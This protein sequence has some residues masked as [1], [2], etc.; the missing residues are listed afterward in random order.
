MQIWFTHL[1][2]R[3]LLELGQR[4]R[5]QP[6]Q[7]GSGTANNIQHGPRQHRDEGV[8]P[9]EGVKQRH[10]CMHAAGKGTDDGRQQKKRY[11]PS[12]TFTL[13]QQQRPAETPPD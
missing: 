11:T 13:T 8:L 1:F 6:H 5:Q 3:Q 2:H 10:H 9:G 7:E 4:A 12:I